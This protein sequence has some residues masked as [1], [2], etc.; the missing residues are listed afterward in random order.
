MNRPAFDPSVYDT[1][2]LAEINR[3]LHDLAWDNIEAQAAY[4]ALSARDPGIRAAHDL[5]MTTQAAH[6]A[7]S[8]EADIKLDAYLEARE[9]AEPALADV[10]QGELI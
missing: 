5:V 7:A 1:A 10:A 3:P 8:A 2:E 9:A 4:R 6:K